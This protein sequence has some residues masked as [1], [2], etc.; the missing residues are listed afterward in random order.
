[1]QAATFASELDFDPAFVDSILLAQDIAILQ[2]ADFETIHSNALSESNVWDLQSVNPP[3]YLASIYAVVIAILLL[4]IVLKF[5]YRNFFEAGLLALPN[6]KVFLLHHRGN[7][8]TDTFPWMAFFILRL[9]LIATAVQYGIYYA[10]G[11]QETVGLDYFG[12][13]LIVVACFYL[14]RL[15][16]EWL[17]QSAM[18]LSKQFKVYYMQHLLITGWLWLPATALIL[19]IF[20]NVEQT[21]LPIYLGIIATVFV[22]VGLFSLL[23]SLLLWSAEVRAHLVYFFIYFCTFKILPYALVLKWISDQWVIFE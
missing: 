13:W 7:K 17:V 8:F 18:G 9:M 20:V 14:L 4:F 10:T 23:R 1:V 2:A 22:L 6:D 3:I 12:L 16:A 15:T 5:F 11:K 19:I 21:T